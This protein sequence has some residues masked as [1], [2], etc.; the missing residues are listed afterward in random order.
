ML[1]RKNEWGKRIAL[2]TNEWGRNL[3][4]PLFRSVGAPL[5][6]L[7]DRNDGSMLGDPGISFVLL[8][9]TLWRGKW[10]LV[11]DTWMYVRLSI[12]AISYHASH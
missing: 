3:I 10:H 9:K 4:S 1:D 12:I 11:R 8:E 2:E 5:S 7:K 6:N